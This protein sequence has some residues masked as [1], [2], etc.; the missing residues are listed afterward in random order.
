MCF[1]STIVAV[2]MNLNYYYFV[3][4]FSSNDLKT[5]RLQ[6]FFLMVCATLTF[7]RDTMILPMYHI[8]FKS[9]SF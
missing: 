5:H 1:R 6:Q 9:G 3:E 4:L 7:C 8:L 2:C